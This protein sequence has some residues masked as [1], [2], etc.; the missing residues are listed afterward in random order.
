M[1]LL[2]LKNNFIWIFFSLIF[3]GCS[4]RFQSDEVIA[5]VNGRKIFVS[6]YRYYLEKL[7]P[8]ESTTSKRS[9]LEIRN[10]IIKE[11]VKRQALI[12]TAED[13]GLYPSEAEISA[14]TKKISDIYPEGSFN[15]ALL[16][17]QVDPK[18]WANHIAD[19][20]A[21][22]KLLNSIPSSERKFSLS[23]E[24]RYFQLHPEKFQKT[25][26]YEVVVILTKDRAG[27][28][29]ALE[30]LKSNK[31]PFR[32]VAKNLSLSWSD[33]TE[34]RA[35]IFRDTA[36]SQVKDALDKLRPGQLSG[37]VFSDV[38][39]ALFKLIKRIQGTNIDFDQARSSIQAA[40][41]RENRA[42]AVDEFKEQ[43]LRSA[44]IEYNRKLISALE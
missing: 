33:T 20:L 4:P 8:V 30:R 17:S 7:Q 34:D 32:E 44:V 43:I 21:I 39:Y 35:L 15:Q 31:Q 25:D 2:N 22:S 13:R 28:E 24:M 10:S 23:E 6:D 16:D 3:F 18:E 12:S 41:R 26:A 5:R 36:S 9:A 40:L 37:I 27:A 38:G 11:L 14:E 29:L 42:K 1:A 19:D